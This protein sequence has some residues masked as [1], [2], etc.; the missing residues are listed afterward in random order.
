MN[1]IRQEKT[2]QTDNGIIERNPLTVKSIG[3][4][5]KRIIERILAIK[6]RVNEEIARILPF[7]AMTLVK[8]VEEM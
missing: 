7:T 1:A 2:K 6:T 3:R 8:R 5:L 4:V